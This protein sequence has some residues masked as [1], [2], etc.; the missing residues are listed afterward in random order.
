MK[1]WFSILVSLL[2]LTSCEHKELCYRH[3]HTTK[4]RVEFDWRNAPDAD[5]EGMCVFFYPENGGDPVRFD[6]GGKQG[7]E[8]DVVVGGYRLIAY[9]NDNEAVRFGGQSSFDTHYGYTREGSLF[10]PI[11]GNGFATTSVPR[12]E[13]SEEEKVVITP[14]MIW[15]CTALDVVISESGSCGYTCVTDELGGR[16]IRIEGTEKVITLYPCELLCHYSYEIRNVENLSSVSKMS[17]T[18]SGM[19]GSMVMSTGELG[20]ECVTLPL[21]AR[22]NYNPDTITGEF[23]TFGHHPENPQLHN[24]VL[25]VWLNDGHKYYYT[26]DLTDQVHTAPD[27]RRVHL[28]VDGLTF[29]LQFEDSNVDVGIDDW[30]EENVD[31]QM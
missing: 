14:D 22:A 6:F 8:I 21:E 10:E 18:L 1:T 4:V 27:P 26:F 2:L 31:I 11:L 12:A 24:L 17:T 9:N 15:G 23:F 13:G 3:P 16:P 20:T 5:P 7:G 29:P 19:S 25:Y 30:I 28:I